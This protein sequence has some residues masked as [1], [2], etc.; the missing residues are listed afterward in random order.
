MALTV[1]A[2]RAVRLDGN[3]MKKRD[4][5]FNDGLYHPRELS[6]DADIC[7][8]H[9]PQ[10]HKDCKGKMCQFFKKEYK[11]RIKEEQSNPKIN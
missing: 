2:I 8:N 11:Q 5:Y 6:V 7:V 10:P 3:K 9:C 4:L 1:N